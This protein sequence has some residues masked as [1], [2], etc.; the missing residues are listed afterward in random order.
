MKLKASEIALIIAALGVLALLAYTLMQSNNGGNENATPAA[1]SLQRAEP[2]ETKSADEHRQSLALEQEFDLPPDELREQMKT[3]SREKVLRYMRLLLERE[4]PA[5]YEFPEFLLTAGS[6][7]E[8]VKR[9]GDRYPEFYNK[10]GNE[11]LNAVREYPVKYE[12]MIEESRAY[13]EL[14]RPT[15]EVEA[16]KQAKAAHRMREQ[17][18]REKAKQEKEVAR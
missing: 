3:A 7:E 10:G 11:L 1:R 12:V 9:I 5:D 8:S 2:A 18:K 6:S 14:Y 13:R 16:E 17:L 15:S 4:L